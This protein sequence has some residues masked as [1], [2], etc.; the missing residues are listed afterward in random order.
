MPAITRI[1][2]KTDLSSAVSKEISKAPS[3]SCKPTGVASSNR[4]S[5]TGLSARNAHSPLPASAGLRNAKIPSGT[6]HRP[7]TQ[8]TVPVNSWS[9]T[10]HA[11]ASG[12]AGASHTGQASASGSALP[13]GW[14]SGAGRAGD[15]AGT[16]G[17]GGQPPEQPTHLTSSH[18]SSA[19]NLTVAELKVRKETLRS[20]YDQVHDAIG[21]LE[22][23]KRYLEGP[24]EGTI[25]RLTGR[26]ANF[27]WRL[28][29][30][31]REIEWAHHQLHRERN[32]HRPE[33]ELPSGA[34]LYGAPFEGDIQGEIE[35]NAD[36]IAQ[37]IRANLARCESKINQLEDMLS[38]DQAELDRWNERLN[39]PPA[40][41]EAQLQ[42]VNA[43]LA[44]LAT[45]LRQIDAELVEL[46]DLKADTE[47]NPER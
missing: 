3:Q 35:F 22:E 32:L 28:R 16:G 47:Q 36:D 8:Q 40:D 25:K 39:N 11:S 31:R 4:A 15:T 1:P 44:P 26:I 23:E 12:Q 41:I 6:T 33:L 24:S 9:D 42:R 46:E 18:A 21:K 37:I 30:F 13:S 43:E 17:A 19:A 10:G 20:E 2:A 7:S 34:V 45:R 27:T 29:S 5:G 38:T 14:A